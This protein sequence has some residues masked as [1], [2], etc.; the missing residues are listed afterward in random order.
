D[1]VLALTVNTNA[2]VLMALELIN[3]WVLALI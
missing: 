1:V 3:A 2:L